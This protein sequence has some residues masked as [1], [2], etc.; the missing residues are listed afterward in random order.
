MKT[1]VEVELQNHPLT[2]D[3]AGR[4]KQIRVRKPGDSNPFV[5]SRE[6]YPK[7]FDVMSECMLAQ[8]AR[9]GNQ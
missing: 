2:D 6:N 3:F 9:R 1:G 7:F 5:F 8:I 4:L